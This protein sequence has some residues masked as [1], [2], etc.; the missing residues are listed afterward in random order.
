[1]QLKTRDTPYQHYGDSVETALLWFF[2]AYVL[3]C[4]GLVLINSRN[5]L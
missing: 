4:F 3:A 5:K 2:L 1:M